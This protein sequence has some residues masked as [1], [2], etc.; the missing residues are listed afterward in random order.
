M[1]SWTQ[2]TCS[3]CT[4]ARAVSPVAPSALGVQSISTVGA[5][6]T[7]ARTTVSSYWASY[8]RAADV[9]ARNFRCRDH[10]AKIHLHARLRNANLPAAYGGLRGLKGNAVL[11]WRAGDRTGVFQYQLDLLRLLAFV[12][13][14]Q[15]M[16]FARAAQDAGRLVLDRRPDDRRV[17]QPQR[18]FVPAFAQE[19]DLQMGRDLDDI[20]GHGGFVLDFRDD[21]ADRRPRRGGRA[22]L[23]LGRLPKLLEFLVG[24]INTAAMLLEYAAELV[25]RDVDVLLAERVVLLVSGI[26]DR[27]RGR[28]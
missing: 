21:R 24:Q 13:D 3:A 6:P 14:K 5:A 17:G 18:N 12:L 25:V 7:K 4:L 1:P 19:V 16:V 8:C 23:V 22:G 9:P 11:A 2:I 20:L 10:R 28:L 26:I 15:A 27:R